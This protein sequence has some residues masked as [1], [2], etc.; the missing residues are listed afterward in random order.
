[1]LVSDFNY[2]LPEQLIAQEPL[3][4][5]AA[6]RMLHLNRVTG[7][8]QDRLFR[9]F[10]DLLRADDLVVFNNTRVF[11]ARL[12][13]TRSGTK[14]QPIS[15]RNPA[16]REF[17]RG[18]VEVLLTRQLSPEPNEW[19]CLVRPGRKIGIGEHLFKACLM[20]ESFAFQLLARLAAAV[21]GQAEHQHEHES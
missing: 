10:P 8:F 2:H 9:D 11:P 21:K 16:A 12:Y 6:S 4:D 1:M 19:E 7:Q 17:L 14:A 13:G 18:R 20:R 3:A 15:M 5:R